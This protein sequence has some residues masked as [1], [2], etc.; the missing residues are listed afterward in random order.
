[1]EDLTTFVVA[2]GLVIAFVFLPIEQAGTVRVS[3][4]SKSIPVPGF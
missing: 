1:M 2:S 3:G 4:I